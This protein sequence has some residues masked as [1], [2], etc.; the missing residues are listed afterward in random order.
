M[1]TLTVEITNDDALKVLQNLQENNLIRIRATHDLNSHIFPGKPFSTEEFKKFISNREH[2]SNMTLKE[3][4]T[5]WL[6]KK[7]QLLK[8]AK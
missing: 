8:S 1:Q 3:A 7:K 2:G 5:K 4:K 6:K